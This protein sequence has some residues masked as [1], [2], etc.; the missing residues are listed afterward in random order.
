MAART[1]E[2]PCLYVANYTTLFR[3]PLNAST[4]YRKKKSVPQILF[5]KKDADIHAVAV[6]HINEQIFWGDFN[7]HTIN[8][9][10]L[11][12][13]NRTMLFENGIGNPNSLSV[14]WTSHML[15]WCDR[16]MRTI[17]VA[18]TDGSYK[19][20]LFKFTKDEEVTSVAVDSVEG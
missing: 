3:I 20:V 8:K 18:S 4:G 10:A 14:D 17:T 11:G 5:H 12:G 2:P 15:Y 19:K 13:S 1:C 9:S 16:T 6:D 7:S